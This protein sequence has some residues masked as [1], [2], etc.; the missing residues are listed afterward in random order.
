[1]PARIRKIKHDDETRAKIKAAMIINR[2]H[3]C[4]EGKIV[5]DA[6]QVSVGKALLSKVLP[7]L[8]TTTLTGDGDNPLQFVSRIELVAPKDR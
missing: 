5:L 8:S 4:L 3:D 7:D 2:F 6:Q 1:M